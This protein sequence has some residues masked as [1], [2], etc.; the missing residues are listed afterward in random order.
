MVPYYNNIMYRDLNSN[1]LGFDKITKILLS[2]IIV[3]VIVV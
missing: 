2:T 1:K 3:N